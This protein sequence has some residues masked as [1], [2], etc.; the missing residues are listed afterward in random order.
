[1]A[2][3]QDCPIKYEDEREIDLAVEHQS[4]GKCKIDFKN[5]NGQRQIPQAYFVHS[6]DW[7]YF[8]LRTR[9]HG[10]NKCG[11]WHKIVRCFVNSQYPRPWC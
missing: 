10:P 5:L 9:P 1:M 3:V 6:A 4:V 11:V 7:L 8:F 2:T